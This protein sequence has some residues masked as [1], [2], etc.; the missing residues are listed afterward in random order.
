MTFKKVQR[1]S[2]LS[3]PVRSQSCFSNL[4]TE[5]LDR[6]DSNRVRITL[7]SGDALYQEGEK[8]RQLYCIQSGKLKITKEGKQGDVLLSIACA[9]NL[10]GHD[11]LQESE[12]THRASAVALEPTQLCVFSK[13]LFLNMASNNQKLLMGM[14]SQQTQ[15]MRQIENRLY[16]LSNKNVRERLATVLLLLREQFRRETPE[17]ELLDIKMSRKELASLAGTV[18]ESVARTLSEFG[19]EGVIRLEKRQIYILSPNRLS[20]ISG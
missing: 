16:T 20:N 6:V 13:E 8:A 3:C 15:Q 9:G 4:V 19:K 12:G 18:I 11:S 10:L 17:G 1:E 2:C 5:D 7:S 14:I